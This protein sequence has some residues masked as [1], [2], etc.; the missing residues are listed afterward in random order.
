MIFDISILNVGLCNDN[1]IFFDD[2]DD[3]YEVDV[4]VI[5]FDVLGFGMFELSGDG[6]VGGIISVVIGGLF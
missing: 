1:G 4:V 3:Y 6:V 5:Y 2:M